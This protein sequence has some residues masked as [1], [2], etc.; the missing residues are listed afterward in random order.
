MKKFQ[1]IAE[2]T[3][4]VLIVVVALLLGFVLIQKHI[5]KE[6]SAN[7]PARM[8]PTVG[9]IV[10]LQGIDWSKHQKTLILALRTDCKYC[11][12]SAPFY[13]R[14]IDAART[15]N[16]NLIAV[17]PTSKEESATHLQKLGLENLDVR[18]ASL[19]TL[20][21]GG[22]PTLILTNSKGEITKS[23]LGKLPPDKES[24]VINQLH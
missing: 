19:D 23:W 14:V 16:I 24:E 10:N 4:N 15:A 17:F 3:A 12:E 22:T 18:Q 6:S 9:S 11:N 5:L 20:K 1:Q 7:F 13:K 21:V 8:Q 2:I